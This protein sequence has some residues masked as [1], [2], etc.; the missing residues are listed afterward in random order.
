MQKELLEIIEELPSGQNVWRDALVEKIC[1]TDDL[2]NLVAAVK[3][4]VKLLREGMDSTG[5]GTL[6]YHRMRDAVELLA[7]E[8]FDSTCGECGASH[9]QA[10]GHVC[11]SGK[12]CK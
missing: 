6:H 4:A 8:P 7:S 11:S 5:T 12:L 10:L 9:Y 2:K 1:K 3:K